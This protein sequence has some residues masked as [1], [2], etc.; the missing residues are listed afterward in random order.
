MQTTLTILFCIL[1]SVLSPGCDRTPS[2]E[3]EQT[4]GPQTR[5]EPSLRTVYHLDHAQPKLPTVRLWLG[6]AEIEAEIARS[7]TEIATGMMFRTE[8]GP[9]EG[10]LFFLGGPRQAAFYMKNT[11]LPLSCAYID[12]QGRILEIHDLEPL[13]EDPVESHS[14]QVVFVLETPRDWFLK[15]GIQPGMLVQSEHG[16][17]LQLYSGNRSGP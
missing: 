11:S 6:R 17:L 3:P 7:V 15:N 1:I 13:V 4:A 14:N 2:L 12:Q 5:P 16:P 10:M 9:N 8:M